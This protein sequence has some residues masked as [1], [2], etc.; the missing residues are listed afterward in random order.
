MFAIF[1]SPDHLEKFTSYLNSK[2]ANII[3]SYEKESNQDQRMVLQHLFT[4]KK[5]IKIKE[6]FYN[7]CLPQRK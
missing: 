1:R 5:V 3:F 2:H 4:T 7:I 6:W